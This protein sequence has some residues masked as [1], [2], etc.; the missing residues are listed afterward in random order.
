MMSNKK[1]SV[2]PVLVQTLVH[3]AMIIA[4]PMQFWFAA[5]T[6][7][8]GIITARLLIGRNA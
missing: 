5:L 2:N 1:M 6:S 4:M 8:A 3:A 7:S